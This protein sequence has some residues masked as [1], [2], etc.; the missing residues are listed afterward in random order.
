MLVPSYPG[1][2]TENAVRCYYALVLS[3]SLFMR[4]DGSDLV[5]LISLCERWD[6]DFWSPQ[7]REE[8]LVSGFHSIK[9]PTV[10][11]IYFWNLENIIF[12]I[13]K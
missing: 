9:N 1:L 11:C 13:K 5:F 3:L 12:A 10:S 6:R 2:T 7:K 4:H 8:D